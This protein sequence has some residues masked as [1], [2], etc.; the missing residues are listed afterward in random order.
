ML[1]R[2]ACRMANDG[3]DVAALAAAV[4]AFRITPSESVRGMQVLDRDAFHAEHQ[5]VAV[6]VPSTLCQKYTRALGPWL[7]GLPRLRS[8]VP[9]PGDAANRAVRLVLLSPVFGSADDLP[10]EAAL[11]IKENE[12]TAVPYTLKVDYAY[13]SSEEVLS[14]ALPQLDPNDVWPLMLALIFQQPTHY[15]CVCGVGGGQGV[16]DCRPHCAR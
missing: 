16:R 11:F 13:W 5:L 2:V 3:P 12:G 9:D 6:K 15:P 10:G 4:R 8:I 14:A 7:L 1:R